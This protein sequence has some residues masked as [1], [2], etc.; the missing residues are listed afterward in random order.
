MIVFHPASFQKIKHNAP[1]ENT[2]Q[3]RLRAGRCKCILATEQ[4][5]EGIAYMRELVLRLLENQMVLAVIWTIL[6]LAIYCSM[7]IWLYVFY[8][9]RAFVAMKRG[10]K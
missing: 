1:R 10:E 9:I 7:T 8:V 2:V 6:T 4:K 5:K 3:N